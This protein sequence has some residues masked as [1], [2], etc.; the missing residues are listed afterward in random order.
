MLIQDAGTNITVYDVNTY[1]VVTSFVGVE[2]TG[3][4][5]LGEWVVA[6]DNGNLVQLSITYQE[7]MDSIANPFINSSVKIH[8]YKENWVVVYHQSKAPMVMLYELTDIFVCLPAGCSSC[9]P[10]YELNSDLECA[11]PNSDEG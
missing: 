7:V 9:H 11:F 3:C 1:A 4:A 6:Y 8:R 5:V 2:F 10:G